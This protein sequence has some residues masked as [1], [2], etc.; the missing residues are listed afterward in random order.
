MIELGYEVFEDNSE[1]MEKL[2]NGE[3]IYL[4]TQESE[5]KVMLKVANNSLTT[6]FV[7]IVASQKA[8]ESIS[9]YQKQ[10]DKE[11]AKKWCNSYDKLNL[12]MQK[13][14]VSLNQKLRIE[15]NDEDILYIVDKNM[16]IKKR[17]TVA[18]K[19]RLNLKSRN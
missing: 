6:R 3:I 9:E 12:L 7:K 19:D 2:E 11:Q 14:G 18:K 1:I 16:A 5:Y 13:N 8:K 4:D 15:P 10:Q 17:K